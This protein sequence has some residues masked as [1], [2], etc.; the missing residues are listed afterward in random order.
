MTDF[1]DCDYLLIGH[2]IA[3]AVLARE[4][5]GRGQR[6][7]VYDEPRPDA[8]SRVAAGLLNPVAGK[9]FALTWRAQETMPTAVA[10]YQALNEEFG[11]DFFQANPI[12]KVF[13]S[14]QEQVQMVA[15]AA[16]GP[17]QGFVEKIETAPIER[18]GLLAPH[19]GA[20]LRGGGHLRVEALL[21]TLASQ[22]RAEGWLREETFNWELLVA[23]GTGASYAPGRLRARQVV[24]CT[25]AAALASPHFGWLPLTPNQGAVLDVA[26]PGLSRAQVLNRGA[27]VVPAP[28]EEQFRVG[29]TYR[30][31]PFAAVPTHD[32]QRE[33]AERLAALTP[34]PF[35][36]LGERRGVRPAV[37]DRRPLLGRHPALPWLS[38][39]GGFGSKGV[40]LAPRL[41]SL[42]AD[43]LGGSGELWPDV[44]LARYYPLFSAP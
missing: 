32:D 35:E 30:W 27:Y 34:L 3:G 10:Y 33:L 9:R 39:F 16:E 24:C 36:V 8:A 7:L 42:L 1:T 22:G 26:V 17:W 28:A 19:G 13:G 23:D 14:A 29:A 4:L 11:E 21:A 31:P 37:R 5:R 44:T 18:P 12:L 41:A 25:G 43:Y 40:S 38:L 6:V 15:R 2:G 20:W